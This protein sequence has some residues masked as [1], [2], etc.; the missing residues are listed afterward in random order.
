MFNLKDFLP[1]KLSILSQSVSGLIASEYETK[2]GLNMNQWRTLVVINA[3]QPVTASIISDLTLLDKMTISR[4]VRSLKARKL[5]Q[6]A[7]SGADGRRLMLSL[8]QSGKK[9]YDDVIPIAMN[10]ETKLLAALTPQEQQKLEVIMEKLVQTT[11]K[12]SKLNK[13]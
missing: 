8:T 4:A 9:I 10:Y 12:I 5:V 1:Y 3:N 6:T 2:F 7:T 11:G 13:P